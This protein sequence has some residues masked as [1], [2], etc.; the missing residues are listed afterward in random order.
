MVTHS[1]NNTGTN[2]SNIPKP[3][4]RVGKKKPSLILQMFKENLEGITDDEANNLV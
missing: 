2:T 3:S 4:T 1:T